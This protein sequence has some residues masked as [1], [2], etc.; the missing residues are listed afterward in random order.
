M[1]RARLKKGDITLRE[2]YELSQDLYEG[3]VDNKAKRSKI[4]VKSVR[5]IKR[6][7]IIFDRKTKSWEQTGRSA[8]IQC[9]ITSIPTSYEKQDTIDRH[10][11]PVTFLIKNINMGIDSPFKFRTGSNARPRFPEKGDSK[12]TR[13]DK[14]NYN[15]K[16]GIQ[17]QFF[18]D[19]EWVLNQ[20]NLLY[21][22]DRTNGPP[23]EKKT[24]SGKPFKGGNP[25]LNPFFDKHS[26]TVFE[27]I[28]LPFF[29]KELSVK[30][31]LV[32]K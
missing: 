22:P 23:K 9:L 2:L 16:R 7:N 20:F 14:I 32:V 25:N 5:I 6:N 12:K 15:I 27:K 28:L 30:L 8:K 19:L 18:F 1:A 17:M 26:L 13:I 24:K 3:S 11:Y 21:G 29:K 10:K 4:D 31:G